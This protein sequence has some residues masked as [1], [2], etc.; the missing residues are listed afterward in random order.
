[1][2]ESQAVTGL[3]KA[4]RGGDSGALEALTPLVY[5]ELRKQAERLMRGERSDH[6]LQTTALV[7]EAYV[8]LIGAE[9][10]WEN[11]VHFYA[12]AARM[13]R[14]ILVNHANARNAAK[15]GGGVAPLSLDEALYVGAGLDERFLDL[16]EAIERLARFDERKAELVELHFFGGLTYEEMASTT[17]LSTSTLDRE[18]RLAKAWL[19]KELMG[20]D[21][22]SEAE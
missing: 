22:D 11:R 7:H 17:G 19:K 4:W 15:R 20:E 16:D 2:S 12:L 5:E 14:R 10:S 6:T 13:M 21:T 18:L 8:K 9:V 3:L 1:M